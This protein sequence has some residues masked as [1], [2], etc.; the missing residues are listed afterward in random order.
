MRMR[1]PRTSDVCIDSQIFLSSDSNSSTNILAASSLLSA[2]PPTARQQ[3]SV[4]IRCAYAAHTLRILC[5]AYQRHLPPL[6]AASHSTSAKIRQHTS[7]YATHTARIR[8]AAYQCHLPPSLR[9]LPQACPPRIRQHTSA[10]YVY[11][12]AYAA[13]HTSLPLC[14]ASQRGIPTRIYSCCIYYICVLILHIYSMPPIEA[15]PPASL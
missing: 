3:A 13:Q 7:A 14:A 2:Q 4:S 1:P 8:C 5:A 15:Y 11:T 9:S 6:C 12:S 10:A